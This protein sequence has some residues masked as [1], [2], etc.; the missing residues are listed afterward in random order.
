[1]SDYLLLIFHHVPRCG[2]TSLISALLDEKGGALGE[3]PLQRSQ[4]RLLDPAAT[5]R[6]AQKT[7]LPLFEVRACW[8]QQQVADSSARLV[9]GHFPVMPYR[10]LPR[11][12]TLIKTMMLFREPGERWW[13]EWRWNRSS[14][15]N[16]GSTTAG[17]VDYLREKGGKIAARSYINYLTKASSISDY[18]S[19]QETLAAID[20][21]DKLDILG[22]QDNLE[23]LLRVL[24]AQGIRLSTIPRTNASKWVP[25]EVPSKEFQDDLNLWL[26]ADR[27]VYRAVQQRLGR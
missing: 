11:Q 10:S 18:P 3:P 26:E 4:V 14:C 19:E 5:W 23:K 13:S 25:F 24:V 21:L 9:A 16:Y 22:C 6:T 1:M 27:K 17:P 12:R 8:L 2:G 15:G 20:A 7:G